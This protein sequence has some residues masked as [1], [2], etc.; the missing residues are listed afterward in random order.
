MAGP[1]PTNLEALARAE[2]DY[3][4][5]NTLL[6]AGRYDEAIA[7]YDAALAVRPDHVDSLLNR[8]TASFELGR[9]D[10][11]LAD[12]D[13]ALALAP[14]DPEIFFNR[15]N[16]LQSLKRHDEALASYER[17]IALQP[18]FADALSN[19]ANVLL[20][21]KRY[22][23]A[24]TACE[25]ALQLQP[26]HLD[27]LINRGSALWELK[28]YN[29]SLACFDRA[30]AM[31]PDHGEA[32]YNRGNVLHQLKRHG[33]ALMAYEAALEANPAQAYALGAA[34]DCVLKLCD[35]KR[36]P[37]YRDLLVDDVRNGRSIISPFALLGYEGDPGLQLK[38][39]QTFVADK[40]PVIPEPLWTGPALVRDKI[41][42]AYLSADFRDHPCGYL[43]EAL[44][45]YHD[46]SRFELIGVSFGP[47]DGS[48]TRA[49][50]IPLFD[51]FHDVPTL[52]DEE[53][54]RLLLDLKVDIAVDMMGYTQDARTGIT[55]LRAAPVQVSWLGFPATM[56]APFIDYIMGD[57]L[58]TPLDQE[59][60]FTEKIAQL[61]HSILV[62]DRSLVIPDKG[63][64]RASQGLPEEGVV[65]CGF[66]GA[67]KIDPLVFDMWM[68]ILQGT[69]GSVLW[70]QDS[71]PQV[72]TTLRAEAD[73]RGV[74]PDRIVYAPWVKLREDHLAR[75]ALADLFLDTLPYNAHATAIDSLLAGLPVLTCLGK[76]FSGRKAAGIVKAIGFDDL[77]A[78]SL[79]DYEA[80]A[81][82]LA[83]DSG[84]LAELKSRLAAN[85]LTYPLLDAGAYARHLESAYET[86]ISVSQRGEAA[87]SFQVQPIGPYAV[88]VRA[89]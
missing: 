73:A 45:P 7:A 30:L 33:E 60:Y 75:Y 15:G 27:A 4:R 57:P 78:G 2:A 86:M 63:L 66:N 47:D 71:G 3:R 18:G 82:N 23:P 77:V 61:P 25:R 55:A 21:L 49:N 11:A 20:A 14:A 65:F 53:G 38:C 64:T 87:R 12:T 58:V 56:G 13:R 81:R 76:S 44:F 67:W 10:E 74:S 80:M 8:G 34:A 83:L 62:R 89:E 50:L 28:R 35:W 1:S 9:F 48:Q 70:L 51:Q 42:V 24:L 79:E 69:P 88:S 17:A 68:R 36:R 39:A 46:R 6:T 22:R 16:A 19:S 37:R 54:G 29:E 5:A 31:A 40:V 43:C 84:A 85:R 52:G 72:N 41:R 59:H 32:L 26:D